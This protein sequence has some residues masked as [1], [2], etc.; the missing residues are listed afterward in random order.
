MT[1][2][3][4]THSL[5]RIERRKQQNRDRLRQAA[6]EAM[7]EQ[8][9]NDLTIRAITERADLGYGTFYLYYT[10]KND[11]VWEIIHILSEQWRMMVDQRLATIP[12]PLREYLSWV[13]VFRFA[14]LSRENFIATMGTNGSAKLLQ[15][16]QNYLADLHETNIRQ[17]FYSAHLDLPPEFLA[18]FISGALVRLLMWWLETDQPYSPSQMA[19]LMYQSIFREQPPENAPADFWDDLF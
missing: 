5:S 16:Y 1:S 18:Q 3:L 2:V 8:G 11:I 6:L 14:L 13:A 15:Y 7:Q 17:G 12:T 9:Y 4:D 10:D 19:D